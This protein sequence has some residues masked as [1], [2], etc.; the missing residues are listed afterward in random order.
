[1]SKRDQ[2]YI[3]IV[4]NR[5]TFSIYIDFFDLLIDNFDLILIK[6]QNN[7]ERDQL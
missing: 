5:S 2:I 3:E 7:I 6:N 4:Q 1:M